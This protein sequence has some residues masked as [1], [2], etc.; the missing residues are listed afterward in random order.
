MKTKRIAGFLGIALWLLC[1]ACDELCEDTGE[2]R[3]VN[4][5]AYTVQEIWIDGVYYGYLY[6]GEAF[7]LEMPSGEY[8]VK[9]AGVNI[10]SVCLYPEVKVKRC[11]VVE[12][13]CA[14]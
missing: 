14:L 8:E 5:S 3:F 2:L 9:F 4:A 12:R 10:G 13:R 11:V 6:P 1:A 7:Q